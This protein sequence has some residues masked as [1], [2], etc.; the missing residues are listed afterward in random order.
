M[1]CKLDS[2]RESAFVREIPKPTLKSFCKTNQSTTGPKDVLSRASCND[3][4]APSFSNSGIS[5]RM[6]NAG[7]AND[8]TRLRRHGRRASGTYRPDALFQ[9]SPELHN[10][11]CAMCKNCK[12]YHDGCVI[13]QNCKSLGEFKTPPFSRRLSTQS[14]S[15]SNAISLPIN[16]A[17]HN[18]LSLAKRKRTT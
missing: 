9:E 7:S 8:Y 13:C 3:F 6:T 2:T 17:A 14:I 4:R 10:D 1:L 5:G 16:V 12:L 11:G 18:I 15:N